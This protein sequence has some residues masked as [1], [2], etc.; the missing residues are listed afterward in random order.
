MAR[1]YRHGA[2]GARRHLAL[3][4]LT[5]PD[6][7][8]SRGD[9][10]A[11]I[12]LNLAVTPP[13]QEDVK[14]K[15]LV[16]TIDPKTRAEGM[17]AL[18]EFAR[19]G[20]LTPDEYYHLGKLHFDQGKVFEC[21]EFF[22]KATRAR[23][24][25]SGEHL[26]ALAR[27]YMGTKN[28]EKARHTVLRLKAFSP[29]G[30]EAAREEARLLK[31][32]A[33][34]AATKANPDLAAAL[35]AE[36][37][38]RILD[39]PGATEDVFARTKSGPL[40]EELEYYPEAEALFARLA[41]QPGA[42]NAHWP[43]ALFLIH[44]KRSDEA[45]R[46]TFQHEAKTSV[47]LT[48]RLLTGAVRAKSPGP[49]AEQRVADWLDAKVKASID[50]FE[51]LT[52]LGSRAELADALRK[53]DDAIASYE[54]AI[55]RAKGLSPEDQRRYPLDLFQNNLAMLLTLH[56][57][58]EADR[59]IATMS[60]VIAIRGPAP[61][62]LDTRA[63]AY[64]VKGGRTGE[65]VEDLKLALVQQHR[66]AYLFHLGWAYDMDPAQRG[67]RDGPLADAKRLGITLDDLHPLEARKFA[68]LYAPR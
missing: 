62:Y 47:E 8:Q 35:T 61:A 45:I 66:A 33:E 36:A 32:E 2:G 55:A 56:R 14:A 39:F 50:P 52:L 44:R 68:E 48:A 19:W 20:D 63:V 64:L 22:E 21:V 38:K 16:Q 34:A 6:A 5:R 24:G 53:Y 29:R 9:A 30:W 15:A 43:L 11:L 26:A 57:P 1:A 46:L 42:A 27:V 28:L 51:Q 18:G 58:A 65:A 4:V 40:L 67:L 25:V 12:D 23:S 49:Q 3:T 17:K 60:D 7:Y 59:A 31:R 37:K 10:M 54:T 41:E 13:D